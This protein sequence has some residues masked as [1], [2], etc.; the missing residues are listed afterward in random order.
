MRRT[1][2]PSLIPLTGVGSSRPRPFPPP[3]ASE[4]CIEGSRSGPGAPHRRPSLL[5]QKPFCTSDTLHGQKVP[6]LPSLFLVP[7][8]LIPHFMAHGLVVLP[9]VN[10][11]TFSGVT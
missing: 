4:P 10:C 11:S 8:T 6:R 9:A 3:G 5:H 2:C 1:A 7:R